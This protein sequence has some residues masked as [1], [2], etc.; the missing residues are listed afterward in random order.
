MRS[1]SA[2]RMPHGRTSVSWSCP[3]WRRGDQARIANYLRA[4]TCARPVISVARPA[5]SPAASTGMRWARRTGS[6]E[7]TFDG[8]WA[9]PV[10]PR[11]L[12]GAARGVRLPDEFVPKPLEGPGLEC[13]RHPDRSPPNWPIC[14]CPTRN[15]GCRSSTS[16]WIPAF[17][18]G[19]S[20]R[21]WRDRSRTTNRRPPDPGCVRM[22][23]R[24]SDD[25]PDD[26]PYYDAE[27]EILERLRDADCGS[28][29]PGEHLGAM[30]EVEQFIEGSVRAVG[31]G[32]R[33]S[34]SR[35]SP[36][37]A[38]PA[39]SRS[40]ASNRRTSTRTRIES[41]SECASDQSPAPRAHRPDPPEPTSSLP[42]DENTDRRNDR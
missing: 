33:Q 23:L 24:Y 37:M 20:V 15:A 22:I 27:D 28:F 14:S 36:V 40:C 34:R 5:G 11:P 32:F 8:E 10:R 29:W 18:K 6:S 4:G 16:R 1:S 3:G 39:R 38:A 17:W 13:P 21:V 41:L 25:L 12:C 35:P 31:R 42:P 2:T 9:W 30:T 26:D 19:W 7:L